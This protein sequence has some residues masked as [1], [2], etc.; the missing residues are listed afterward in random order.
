MKHALKKSQGGFWLRTL[1]AV[2][3]SPLEAWDYCCAWRWG[4][5]LV[6]LKKPQYAKTDWC[7][8]PIKYEGPEVESSCLFVSINYISKNFTPHHLVCAP[9]TPLKPTCLGFPQPRASFHLAWYF[10]NIWDHDKPGF[11][12]ESFPQL[13]LSSSITHL[14]MTS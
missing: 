7:L 14:I 8:P 12:E 13:L 9:S 10:Y 2:P 6:G 11:G 4:Q 3:A 5:Q 1:D